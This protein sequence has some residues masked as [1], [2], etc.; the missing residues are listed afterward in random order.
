MKVTE[1]WLDLSVKRYED[2]NYEA[3]EALTDRR[4]ETDNWPAMR[5]WLRD[6]ID[7]TTLEVEA[8]RDKEG[9]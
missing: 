7:E 3:Y 1:E 5:Q 2:G 8:S 4:R 9:D 6:L